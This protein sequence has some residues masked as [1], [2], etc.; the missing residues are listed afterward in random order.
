MYDYKL[1]TKVCQMYYLQRLSK[2]E[3][4]E[5]LHISRFK[6]ARLLE[7]AEKEGIIRIQV[8]SP[9]PDMSKL[10]ERLERELGLRAAV[11]VEGDDKDIN[12][13]KQCLGVAAGQFL[14][15]T[16]Q[17]GDVLGIAWGT[18]VAEVVRHLPRK[19]SVSGIRI[20]Q[21]TGGLG[22]LNTVDG[23]ELVR[24]MANSLNAECSVLFAP[25]IVQNP[26]LKKALMEDVGIKN[27][28]DFF[29]D[30]NIAL[31]GIGSWYPT[32]TSNLFNTGGF[33]DEDVQ[34]LLQQGAVGDIFNHFV[35]FQGRCV[36]GKLAER[37]IAIDLE[38]AREID[39]VI[40]VA[41]GVEKSYGILGAVRSGLVSA[42]VTDSYTALKILEINKNRQ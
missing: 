10:E 38:L 12:N 11:V 25:V 39:Y 3:I 23:I 2:V 15:E 21:V 34:W 27:T 31:V 19:T 26:E 35:D 16:I 18:T 17:E 33:S 7:R 32:V 14:R 41:G 36:D 5:K 13:N 40:A 29:A 42:L 8:V 1:I 4:A 22:Q 28:I 20:V 6:V 37:L 9:S 30:I 24:R